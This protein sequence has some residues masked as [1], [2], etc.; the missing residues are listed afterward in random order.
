MRGSAQGDT[1]WG[2]AGDNR[3]EGRA[4]DDHLYGQEGNDT[5]LGGDD[6][7][8]LY[9][10]D[11]DDVLEGGNGYDT[12]DGG[13]GDDVLDGG[14]GDDTVIGGEGAD[15]FVIAGLGD[16]VD[17]FAD[18]TLGVDQIG[19][20]SA[21]FGIGS[22]DDVDFISGPGAAAGDRAALL[23]DS[24]TGVL[25]YDADGAGGADAVAIATLSGA[26]DLGKE[27]FVLT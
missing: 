14:E 5:I 3:V 22:L 25:S 7:D 13:D 2:D 9:G 15:V 26:P 11:G 17:N 20:S 8:T 23:Y 16:G 6:N 19:L 1:F 4:G 24:E 10:E 18:F 27:A 21:V 12:L